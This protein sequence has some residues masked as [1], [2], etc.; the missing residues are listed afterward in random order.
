MCRLLW[1]RPR[2]WPREQDNMREEVV[3]L[4]HVGRLG[5]FWQ[6]KSETYKYLYIKLEHC[7]KSMFV[8]RLC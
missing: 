3:G 1:R 4:G 8:G 7:F 5:H 2:L 6:K